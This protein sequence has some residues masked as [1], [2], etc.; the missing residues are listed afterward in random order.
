MVAG[1]N[2]TNPVKC[3]RGVVIIPDKSFIEVANESYDV[4]IELKSSN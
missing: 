3:S 1:L 4:S 2:G